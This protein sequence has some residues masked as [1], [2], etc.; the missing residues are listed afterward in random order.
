MSDL[1]NPSLPSNDRNASIDILRGIALAGMLL[2][3]NPGSWSNVYWP[4]LHAPWHGL[5]PTD[6]VFP[7]FLFVVGASMAY[8]FVHQIETR[9]FRWLG[10][11]RRAFLLI[12][13]GVLLSAFPYQHPISEWRLPGV[14]QRIGLCFLLACFVLRFC[15]PKQIILVSVISL[16]IY[17]L[18][19]YGYSDSPYAMDSNL[20]RS[21]DLMIFAESQLYKGY[22]LVFDPEGVLSTLP[23]TV[24]VLLGYLSAHYLRA[25]KN[26]TDKI[27]WLLVVGLFTSVA[28]L[29]FSMLFPINKSLW[30]STFV[31]VTSGIACILLALIIAYWDKG[32]RRF[33]LQW[34]RI[35][36]SN[37]ILLFVL[38]GL[39]AR[40]L[41]LIKVDTQVGVLS[42]KHLL[43]QT[44]ANVFPEKIA[45]LIFA[46]GFMLVF[47]LLAL[48]LYKR[49]IFIKL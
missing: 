48:L 3:N 28:G 17:W 1:G 6:L 44:L 8:S 38:A 9:Q 45:S 37:P 24:T 49:N 22:G 47:Y 29:I 23:A 11:F 5:T 2:V 19:L 10:I 27:K 39:L 43:Y 20:A 16:M 34:L 40:I 15:R 25:L 4:L 41:N 36:G 26:D 30:S 12:L 21:I 32:K 31:L 46:L 18:G 7:F 14:L 33:G 35:Y 13:I 42:I